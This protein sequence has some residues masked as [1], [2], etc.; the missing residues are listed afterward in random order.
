LGA[1]KHDFLAIALQ[2]EDAKGGCIALI[3]SGV[4]LDEAID[5]GAGGLEADL[6]FE[7]VDFAKHGTLLQ[8][9]SGLGEIGLCLAEV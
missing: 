4:G 2:F 1:L 8:L 6:G 7:A 9:D 3:V 5:M